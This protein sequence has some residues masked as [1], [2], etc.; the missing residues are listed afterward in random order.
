MR[1]SPMKVGRRTVPIWASD[2][3][4][5]PPRSYA[6]YPRYEWPPSQRCEAKNRSGQRCRKYAL[7]MGRFC[8]WLARTPHHRANLRKDAGM[9]QD[10]RALARDAKVA[11]DSAKTDLQFAAP[12]AVRELVR[13]LEDPGT[14]PSVRA[15]VA[16]VLLKHS[17]ASL[18]RV[19]VDLD[20]TVE[21]VDRDAE[22]RAAIEPV[23]EQLDRLREAALPAPL[24][25]GAVDGS[26]A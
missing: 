26:H 1:L 21:A 13:L 8:K 14:A 23:H 20:A 4:E 3:D 5:A 16:E 22:R 18:E 10:L 9:V 17:G 2:V 11:L 7:R 12:V 15:R 6:Y 19:Q 25:E 24:D